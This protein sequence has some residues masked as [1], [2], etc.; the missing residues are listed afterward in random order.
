MKFNNKFGSLFK[1]Y[2]LRAEFSTLSELGRALADEGFIFEDSIFSRWQKGNRMPT[3]RNL[4]LT[5]IRIFAQKGSL[6]SLSEANIF[7]ES[8]GQRYL[9]EP[10]LKEITK[11]STFSMKLPS[12]RKVID[13]LILIGRSKSIL[14]SGWIREGIKDSESV[15]EHSFRLTVLTMILAD[16]LG[17]DKE[18][19]IKMAI[20][21]DLG[22]VVTGDIVWSRGKF[23]DIKKR[24]EKEN[25]E[26]EGIEKVF[27]V[28]EK[29]KEYVKIFEE[30]ID[31][32]SQEAKI[33]W[34]LD[35][36]EMA[37]QALEYERNQNKN[38][39]EFFVNAD[40]QIYLLPLRKFMQEIL[41]RRVKS[42]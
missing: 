6:T 37:L 31:R 14:R 8:A 13:F 30:M 15:A 20:I 38:L 26:K 2:R 28:I 5:M 9:T 25:L 23:I 7:L 32:E 12:S 36:L 29:S 39:D 42:K 41:K 22:E 19:L 11:A 24:T 40:L 21:H 1:K 10:E 3:S 34:Q 27:K 33:F 18:K 4:L 16:Q 17:L 35:K